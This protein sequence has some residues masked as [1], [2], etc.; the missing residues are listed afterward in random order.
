LSVSTDSRPAGIAGSR[1]CRD[2]EKDFPPPLR[3]AASS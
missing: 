2:S 3:R 1:C